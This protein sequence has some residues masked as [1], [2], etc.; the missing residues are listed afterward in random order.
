MQFGDDERAAAMQVGAVLLFGILIISMAT[1]QATVV[2]DQNKGVEFNHNQEVQGQ[3]Q[4]LRNSVVSVP[5]GGGGSV[6]VDLGTTYPSRTLFVNPGP[7]YGSL[8][9][10][11]TNEERVNVSI[12][13]ANATD[14]EVQDFWN[15]STRAFETGAIVYRPNYHEYENPPTTVYEHSLLYNQFR[16][17]NLTITDQSLVSGDEIT[18]VTIDGNLSENGMGA[19]SVTADPVSASTNTVTVRNDSAPIN[20]TVATRLNR[21]TWN[22]TL[23]DEFDDGNVVGIDYDPDGPGEFALLTIS[24]NQSRTYDLRIA[25]VGVGSGA[26]DSTDELYLA[27]PMLQGTTASAEVRDRYNNPVGGANVTVYVD[28]TE[29]ATKE[30]GSDGR[31]SYEANSGDTVKFSIGH[32][33]ADNVTIT[34]PSGGSGSAYSI[35]WQDPELNSSNVGLDLRNCTDEQCT[36]DVG[37][38]DDNV[39]A[40][41]GIANDQID[42]VDVDFRVNDS[43]VATVDPSSTSD[44]GDGRVWTN[45]TASA[46]GTVSVYVLSSGSSDRIDV[47]VENV[48]GGTNSPPTADFTYSPSSPSTAD[49]VNFTDQSSDPDGSIVSW[50]WSFGDGTSSTAQNPDHSYAD[51]GTYTVTLTVED[52]NGSTDS[53]SDTVTVSNQ[54]PN[55]T[56]TADCNGDTCQFDASNASD[57][58]GNVQSYDWEFGDGTTAT[59]E[60]VNHTY[61]S[62]GDYTVNLTVTDDDGATDTASKVVSVSSN[63]PPTADFTYSC[64]GRDC[65]F[66]STATDDSGVTGYEWDFDG[67]GTVDATGENTTHTYSTGGTYDVNHTVYDQQGLSDSVVKQVNVTGEVVINADATASSGSKNKNSVVTFSIGNNRGGAVDVTDVTLNS[68]SNGKVVELE[69]SAYGSNGEVEVDVGETGTVDAVADAASYPIG[70]AMTLG[71]AATVSSGTNASIQLAEFDSDGRDNK[72]NVESMT[73]ETITVTVHYTYDGQRYT[74]TKTLTVS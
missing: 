73:G 72:V 6:T 54:A 74:V 22:E 46:N 16:N 59:G 23:S 53:Y 21:S 68:T 57:P 1:Y 17:A 14:A 20:V 36:W 50:S 35:D 4:D 48:S 66:N 9:T 15:G 39:M 25:K 37:A 49:V 56:F 19:A 29:T 69:D 10:V 55:A 70:T 40:L 45:L 71:N 60:T 64:T 30:S 51:D 52:G 24:L 33:E 26:S 41:T 13:N 3:M 63:S 7:P 28:G 18:L 58:D 32:S 62:G 5:R 8:R 12:E 44:T 34:V 61:S 31:V 42:N 67:D 27:D 2:P 38:S 11:G 43:N 47:A 65:V